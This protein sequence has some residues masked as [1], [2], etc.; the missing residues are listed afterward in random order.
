[1]TKEKI[2][3]IDHVG[4]KAGMDYY[5]F[6]LAKGI[7]ENGVPAIIISNFTVKEN[8]IKCYPY[9]IGHTSSRVKKL[10]NHIIAFIKAARTCRRNGY[11]RAIVHLFSYEIKDV[12]ALLILKLWRIK[13][14]AIVHDVESLAQSGTSGLQGKIFGNLTEKLVVHNQFSYD[15]LLKKYGLL[16]SSKTKVIPH[17]NFHSLYVESISRQSARNHF[18]MQE[19]IHYLLFFGQIKEVKGLEILLKAMPM[20]PEN[21]HLLIAGKPWKNDFSQYESLI[22]QLG[23]THRVHTYIGFIEDSDR[24]LFMKACDLIILPYKQIFQSGV[25]LMAISYQI[26]II[27][28]DLLPMKELISDNKTGFLFAAG[29]E[30][31]LQQTIIHALKNPTLLQKIVQQAYKETERNNNW[32]KI[33]LSFLCW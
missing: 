15:T 11:K 31:S 26:P 30:V 25:M 33:A 12:Y 4:Q 17:G 2:A 19:N 29:N 22:H 24:D 20:L 9:F 23:I 8:R 28:S 16:V 18:S 6:L 14:I 7:I 1:M 27:A 10:W 3:I 13:V 21:I 32:D 5:T